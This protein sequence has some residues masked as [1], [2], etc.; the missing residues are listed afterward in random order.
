MERIVPLKG[1]TAESLEPIYMEA[2]A[3]ELGETNVPVEIDPPFKQ[4]LPVPEPNAIADLLFWFI[5]NADPLV[6]LVPSNIAKALL[7]FA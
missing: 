5:E 3:K 4:M 7:G 1:S 6:E 2:V